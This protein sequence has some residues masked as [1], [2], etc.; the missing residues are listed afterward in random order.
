MIHSDANELPKDPAIG[1]LSAAVERPV[2][3]IEK[4]VSNVKGSLHSVEWAD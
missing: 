2:F 3:C 4:A 1:K